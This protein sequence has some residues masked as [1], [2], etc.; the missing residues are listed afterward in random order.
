MELAKRNFDYV[1]SLYEICKFDTKPNPGDNLPNYKKHCGYELDLN[2]EKAERNYWLDRKNSAEYLCK[3][4]EAY[5]NLNVTF[6]ITVRID[7][8]GT[9]TSNDKAMQFYQHNLNAKLKYMERQLHSVFLGDEVY[10]HGVDGQ[11]RQASLMKLIANM[12][13]QKGHDNTNVVYPVTRE[14]LHVAFRGFHAMLLKN[15]N[16]DKLDKYKDEVFDENTIPMGNYDILLPYIMNKDD[17][18]R[19]YYVQ[20]F[21]LENAHPEVFY[22]YPN[23]NYL[24]D[25]QKYLL[26]CRWEKVKEKITELRMHIDSTDDGDKIVI[27][28]FQ[29]QPKLLKDKLAETVMEAVEKKLIC[30]DIAK[31]LGKFHGKGIYHRMIRQNSVVLDEEDGKDIPRIINFDLAKI[32]GLEGEHSLSFAWKKALENEKN[33]NSH[34]QKNNAYN[35]H[36]EDKNKDKNWMAYDVYS[37]GIL[38]MDILGN[39]QVEIPTINELKPPDDADNAEIKW[40]NLLREMCADDP[41]KR[42]EMN[43][44]VERLNG[45]L[46]PT[47]T[48]GNNIDAQEP[49]TPANTAETDESEEREE[50]DRDKYSY[51]SLLEKANLFYVALGS[52]VKYYNLKLTE[53]KS[54]ILEKYFGYV[55]ADKRKWQSDFFEAEK[56][57]N[58]VQEKLLLMGNNFR[59]TTEEPDEQLDMQQEEFGEPTAQGGKGRAN[60]IPSESFESNPK[61]VDNHQKQ[62]KRNKP[63]SRR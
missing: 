15:S 46:F 13:N 38:F 62:S 6:D 40:W 5:L 3:A 63:K 12:R 2:L 4:A 9:P 39:M 28:K 51:E 43:E 60:S 20:N 61:K 17:N 37:M 22:Y 59:A 19:K 42:P 56:E 32:Q 33:A 57:Y 7:N 29:S 14:N 11:P 44:V 34:V 24:D 53:P 48:T 41:D 50:K 47:E 49:V 10:P 55:N 54:S 16:K 1:K 25:N 35:S 31:E 26:K 58:E 8:E 18:V 52:T 21:T 45:I 23:T 27:Y 36:P 30:L